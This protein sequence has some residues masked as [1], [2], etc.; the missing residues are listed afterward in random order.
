MTFA[1]NK[2]FLKLRFLTEIWKKY[3]NSYDFWIAKYKIEFILDLGRSNIKLNLPWIWAVRIYYKLILDLGRLNKKYFYPRSGPFE[4]AVASDRCLQSSNPTISFFS[5]SR[6]NKNF[7]ISLS[8]FKFFSNFTL[9][10]KILS[11][12]SYFKDRIDNPL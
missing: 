2:N 9:K 3:Q 4:S 8:F 10:I 5:I 12:A 6:W 11:I 7:I 1:T